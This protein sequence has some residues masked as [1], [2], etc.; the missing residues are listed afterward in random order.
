[1]RHVALPAGEQLSH[2]KTYM[3]DS[4]LD[5]IWQLTRL[6][7]SPEAIVDQVRGRGFRE[8][9]TLLYNIGSCYLTGRGVKTS[10]PDAWKWLGMSAAEGSLDALALLG[11]LHFEGVGCDR[12]ESEAIRFLSQAAYAGHA[13]AFYSLGLIYYQRDDFLAAFRHFNDAAEVE[14]PDAFFN[15]A[16]MYENGEGVDRSLV[17]AT[18]WYRSAA[19]LGDQEARQALDR[20]GSPA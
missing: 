13:E 10:L 12:S 15:L 11:R 1:M 7:V 14:H 9:P 2:R 19:R 3:N 8:L 16:V 18:R 6:G 17:E 20:L 4:S 5:L